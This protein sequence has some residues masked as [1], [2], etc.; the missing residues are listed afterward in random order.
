[1]NFNQLQSIMLNFRS[2]KSCT[3]LNFTLLFIFLSS[4]QFLFAQ[5]ATVEGFKTNVTPKSPE[6]ATLFK[7]VDIPV[8]E[9]TGIPNINVP[10][11]SISTGSM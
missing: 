5:Q 7:F 9:Y 10:I 2:F 6:A 3:K 11:S 4:F 8:S 1:M